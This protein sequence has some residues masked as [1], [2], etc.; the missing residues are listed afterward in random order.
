MAAFVPRGLTI[1]KRQELFSSL[2]TLQT[3]TTSVPPR[4]RPPREVMSQ[5]LK[6]LKTVGP[7]KTVCFLMSSCHDRS[8]RQAL[9]RMARARLVIWRGLLL[10][11]CWITRESCRSGYK[12][13]VRSTCFPGHHPCHYQLSPRF[14]WL[15]RRIHLQRRWRD[16]KCWSLRPAAGL[17]LGPK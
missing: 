11:K 16:T 9:R 6:L 3:R 5:F 12:I 10:W 1:G 4:T 7:M 2:A 8:M 14:T 15:A 17:R 13:N